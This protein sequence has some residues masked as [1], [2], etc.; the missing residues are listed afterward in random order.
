M[1]YSDQ[2]PQG[3]GPLLIAHRGASGYLPEH[4]LAAKALAYGL[5]ADFLEQDVIA[6]RDDQLVVLHDVHIDRVSDV[7]ERFPDRARADGRWYARDFDLAELRSLRL[8]ER[9]TADRAATVFPQRF[10]HRAGTFQIVTLAEEVEFVHGL[11]RATGRNVGI[12]PEIKRPA[13][14]QQEGVDLSALVLQEL[15]KAGYRQRSDPVYLQCFDARETR[16]LREE[17]GCELRLVQLI[18]DNSWQEAATDYESLKSPSGLARVAEYADAIGPWLEQLYSVRGGQPMTSGFAEEAHRHGLAVHPYTFRAD[19]L[20]EGF[21]DFG[22]M[23]R[24]FVDTLH[25]GGLFTDFPD[26]VLQAVAER[27]TPD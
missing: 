15:G 9:M 10:P 19:A 20:P 18:G 13:W 26:R 6:T 1:K 16:R 21:D 3:I 25:I 2:P 17:L 27:G 8:F 22:Y 14:H 12:Y 4:T 24:W 5:G 7:V 11:N 23:V